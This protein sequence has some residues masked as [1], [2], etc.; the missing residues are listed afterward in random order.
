MV[1]NLKHISLLVFLFMIS[2]VSSIIVIHSD[3]GFAVVHRDRLSFDDIPYQTAIIMYRNGYEYLM[4]ITG[5]KINTGSNNTYTI[6]YY[7]P[8]PSKPLYINISPITSSKPIDI[9]GLVIQEKDRVKE[10]AYPSLGYIS[11]L[12]VAGYGGEHRYS[13]L[14]I[15][16]SKF[17][18]LTLVRS[19]DPDI[20]VFR[21]ILNI[22]GY[23]GEIPQKMV[24]AINHYKEL[25][26]KYFILG[27]MRISKNTTIFQQIMLRTDKIV[28]PLYIDKIHGNTWCN[29]NILIITEKTVKEITDPVT[30]KTIDAGGFFEG[31]GYTLTIAG[32]DSSAMAELADK[33]NNIYVDEVF[34]KN[35]KNML[36]IDHRIHKSYYVIELRFNGIIYMYSETIP[37]STINSDVVAT[38]SNSC[39]LSKYIVEDVVDAIFLT[40]TPF[41]HVFEILLIILYFIMLTIFLYTEWR[42]KNIEYYYVIVE[43]VF[44]IIVAVMLC[45]PLSDTV[46]KYFNTIVVTRLVAA[47]TMMFIPLISILV[48]KTV[49]NNV[50]LFKEQYTIVN[51]LL[52]IFGWNSLSII[53]Y[54]SL[55]VVI[56][57][58]LKHIMKHVSTG[59]L[60]CLSLSTFLSSTAFTVMIFTLLATL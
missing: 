25:E 37:L 39:D 24:D 29:I 57:I 21:E 6:L 51:L 54:P 49:P 20:A 28:Y 13:L 19:S 53:I 45:T 16:S 40:I 3:S 60:K 18:N 4:I 38:V 46:F 55:I 42:Y 56:G 1:L 41:R 12:G 47:V 50:S 44:L 22:I 7:L 2:T 8:L 35:F 17:F 11:T 48:L 5:Y 34:Q 23:R 14:S 59:I 33:L 36:R 32:Y 58:M 26:W 15:Q 52:I 27:V 31:L 30:G 9:E 10:L 43:T